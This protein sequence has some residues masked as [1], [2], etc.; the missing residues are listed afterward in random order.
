MDHRSCNK[1]LNKLG[2]SVVYNIWVFVITCWAFGQKVFQNFASGQISTLPQIKKRGNDHLPI[3]SLTIAHLHNEEF[4]NPIYPKHSKGL[5]PYYP[6][7]SFF[8]LFIYFWDFFALYF[9]L[10]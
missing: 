8:I 9:F 1:Q 4:K 2:N 3:F 10:T 5:F 6:I 7:N